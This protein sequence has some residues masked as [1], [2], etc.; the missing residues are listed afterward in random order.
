M[1]EPLP[2]QL[3]Q[4]VEHVNS[5]DDYAARDPGLGERLVLAVGKAVDDVPSVIID[6][7]AVMAEALE[8]D[9]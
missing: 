8:D 2:A 1:T 3:Q 6:L 4:L 7:I 9:E 5:V